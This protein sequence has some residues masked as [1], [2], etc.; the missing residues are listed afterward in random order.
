MTSEETGGSG[1]CRSEGRQRKVVVL[2]G[3]ES[4]L[5]FNDHTCMEVPVFI[6]VT[7]SRT[8]SDRVQ[9][10]KKTNE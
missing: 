10:P 5:E 8:F 1:Q 7:F 3:A 4:L 6:S 2:S 9:I